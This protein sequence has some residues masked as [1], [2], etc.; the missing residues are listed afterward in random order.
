MRIA[1]ISYEYPPDTA[2]GGIGT[3]TWQAAHLLA[4]RGHSVEVFASSSKRAG[5]FE[6]GKTLLNLVGGTGREQFS[7]GVPAVF[8]D[9][10]AFRKFDVVES[11]ECGADGLQI[12][13]L[14]PALPH[15]I[16]LHTPSELLDLVGRSRPRFSEW[17]RHN[18]LRSRMAFGALRRFQR[19]TYEPYLASLPNLSQFYELE[20]KLVENCDWVVS[21]SRAML[22]WAVKNWSI[23]PACSTV[24]PNPYVPSEQ[25]LRLPVGGAGKVIGFF[26]RLEERKGISDLIKAIP[27][28]ISAEPEAR[29]RFVGRA[30]SYP[31][32][33][34]P[35]DIYLRRQLR[36]FRDSIE[37]PGALP[38]EQMP[39]Q[40]GGVAVCVFPSVWENF[41]NV[42][43]E[44]MSAGRAIV[45]SNAGGMGEMLQD[46]AHGILIPPR[47]PKAIADAVVCLLRSPELRQ[48]L[49]T[50]ARQRVL[51]AYSLERV[52]PQLEK[53][54]SLA[55]ARNRSSQN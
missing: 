6:D 9:R 24:V 30:C 19:P 40:Y 16:K 10:H 50:T 21:P 39:Q 13:H 33:G 48:R 4:E 31:G 26:G 3:Y 17:V 25:L 41:P 11:P 27:L 42:C 14:F 2:F 23:V 38:L 29:F 47:D 51:E 53:S 20:R 35:F 54:Y 5:C 34:E 49:G 22:E 7:K 18:V 55:I 36:R 44:A 12:R 52:G 32:T 8:S 37:L 1:F 46:G 15:V 28:I 43:L 45:A